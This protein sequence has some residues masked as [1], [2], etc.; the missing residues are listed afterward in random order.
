MK[1][2][3][4]FRISRR[5]LLGL[6]LVVT[7]STAQPLP[8]APDTVAI[9]RHMEVLA[10]DSL[11]GRGTGTRGG[12]AA[13]DYIV[14]Q[15]ASWGLQPAGGERSF[16]QQIPV[17]GAIALKGTS[18]PIPAGAT[19]LQPTLWE[20]FILLSA[21][22]HTF[23]PRPVPL[24]FVGYGIIAPEFDYNDYRELDVR[25]AVVVFLA[26]EPASDDSSYF[27][28]PAATMHGSLHRKQEVALARGARGTILL[29][30]QRDPTFLH[31]ERWRREFSFE[32]VRLPYGVPEQLHL[33]LRSSVADVLFQGAP[34]PFREVLRR[35][36]VGGVRSIPLAAKLTFD[37]RFHERDSVADNIAAIVPGG[38]P[39]LK[40]SYVLVGAH[41]D[42][43]GIG[44]AVE[45]D[46]IYNGLFDNAMGVSV[47]LELARLFSQEAMR[48]ARSILFVFFTGE[49]KG[50]IGSRYYTSN[51]LRP[52]SATVAMINIDGVAGF[53]PFR[54]II[55][56]GAD[57]S[58]IR[59]HVA[60]VASR[61]ALTIESVPP[62]FLEGDPL[63]SSDHWSFIEAG[64]PSMLLSEGF[65][66]D[67][68]SRE[69]G[70]QRF[71]EWGLRRYHRPQDDLRQ[72]IAMDAVDQHATVLRDIILEIANTY[73]PPQ[74][75]PG[76]PYAMARLRS[77][78]E[79][80]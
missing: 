25:G 19:P 35:D 57:L 45:G 2:R 9:R 62:I 60:A 76:S 11:E 20:E 24:I 30:T 8:P 28:G 77:V 42:H 80:R 66:Y 31:W 4:H 22:N 68:T 36:S 53:E 47:Q 58:T 64:V 65:T 15:L 43:L 74:W 14:R 63:S 78:A 70:V 21:G 52:L 72:P 34:I 59:D 40:G 38:D 26:G 73:Q 71:V 41:Y 10:D 67:R 17:H 54:S 3:P 44:E 50:L 32:D 23:I 27:G 29:P 37:G 12:S 18:L 75:L 7:P 13:A 5:T 51:P 46:S 79:G 16:R 49:E 1:M 39:L 61:H 6:A 69:E 48:P 56:V 33:I 55:P